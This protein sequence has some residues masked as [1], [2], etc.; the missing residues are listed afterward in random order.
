MM[1]A[2]SI[3]PLAVGFALGAIVDVAAPR[4][5]AAPECVPG[6]PRAGLAHSLG[7]GDRSAASQPAGACVRTDARPAVPESSAEARTARSG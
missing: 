1:T 3:F 4:P 7:H 2:R 5:P 6:A